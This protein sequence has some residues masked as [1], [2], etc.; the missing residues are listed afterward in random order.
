MKLALPTLTLGILLAIA[1]CA[2]RGSEEA[3]S[4]ATAPAVP[5]QPSRD[6]RQNDPPADSSM[7]G[8]TAGDPAAGDGPASY[9]GF[10]DAE[11]GMDAEQ[12]RAVWDGELDGGPGDG[13]GAESGGCFHLSPAGQPSIAHFALM[14]GDGRFARYS[15]AND[16]VTAPGGGRRGMDDAGIVRLYGQA[17]VERRPHKYSDGE[18]LRIPDPAGSAAVLIFETDAEGTVTEWRVGMPP[19]VDYVEGCA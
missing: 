15:V 12:V 1:A 9:H 11:F 2:D 7:P 18:Y 16:D 14:F 5:D 17:N 10:A 19:Q 13:P 8:N 3:T 6:T 4:S